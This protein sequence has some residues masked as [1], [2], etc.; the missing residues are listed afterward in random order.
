MSAL[1]QS[2]FFFV[3]F[4]GRCLDA[5]K[6][7]SSS[8]KRRLFF[9]FLELSF[10]AT[11][12]I[13]RLGLVFD[14][15]TISLLFLP[16]LLLQTHEHSPFGKA[17]SRSFPFLFRPFFSSRSVDFFSRPLAIVVLVASACFSLSSFFFFPFLEGVSCLEFLRAS[18]T[19]AISLSLA[20]C[21]CEFGSSRGL[22]VYGSWVSRTELSIWNR[23]VM[24]STK[25]ASLRA[26]IDF[27]WLSESVLHRNCKFHGVDHLFCGS[28][29]N[30]CVGR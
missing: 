21:F 29:S 7:A 5:L 14:I 1:S 9:A 8:L 16:L 2:W 23:R 19:L 10:F 24:S 3:L 25:S 20:M 17:S 30:K 26:D 15:L 18:G 12:S 27:G 28:S 6:L 4:F 11:L 13:P 22:A